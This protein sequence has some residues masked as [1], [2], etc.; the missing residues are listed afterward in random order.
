MACTTRGSWVEG[1]RLA[2]S[3]DD[4][5]RYFAVEASQPWRTLA[6]CA[7]SSSAAASAA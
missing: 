7:Q 4:W 6:P 2:R 3:S 5:Q 1:M